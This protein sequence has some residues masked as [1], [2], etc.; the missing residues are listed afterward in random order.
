MTYVQINDTLC[1]ATIYGRTVDNDWNGRESKQISLDMNLVDVLK[2]FKDD[3]EWSIVYQADSYVD[4]NGETVIPE[5]EVYDNSEY[6]IVGT[7][8]VKM[9]KPTAKEINDI[10]MGG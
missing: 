6:C 8:S 4:E 7:V 3:V 9:G 1:P 2:L 10:L 5:P